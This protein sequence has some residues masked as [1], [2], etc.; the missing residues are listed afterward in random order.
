MGV[1]SVLF[2]VLSLSLVSLLVI[3][4]SGLVYGQTVVTV[5]VVENKLVTLIGEGYDEDADDLTFLWEQLDGEPVELSSYIIPTP[6][7]MAPE[8]VNGLIKVLT[9]QLTVTDPTGAESS[10]VVEIIVNPVNHVPIVSAGRDKLIFPTLNAITLVGSAVDADDDPLTFS[11]E[12]TSGPEIELVNTNLR[13]LTIISTAIDFSNFTPMTFKLTAN[14]E[15]GGAASD[16]ATLYPYHDILT[17]RLITIDAGPLQTVKEGQTVTMDVTGETLNG[18]PISYSWAQLIGPPVSLSNYVGDEVQFI[19]PDLEG[20]NSELLSFQ[21]TGYSQGNGWASDIAMVRV[22]PFNGPPTADAGPDQN[23]SQNVFVNLEGSGT[24]P[25][26]TKLRFQWSQKSGSEVTLYQRSFEDVYFV[27]PFIDGDSA[28]L[29]FGL[30]VTDSDGNFDTDDVTITVSKQNH[31]PKANAGPDRRIISDSQVT[32]TGFG[33]DPDGDEITYSWEQISGD[34]VPFDGSEAKISFTAPTVTSGDTKRVILQLKVTDTL[35]QSDTD[36]LTLIVVPENN[37]PIVDA[38]PDQEVDENTIGN[39]FCSAF[40]VEN[41][42]LTYT[43][44]AATS[45]F[46]IHNPSN[47]SATYEAPSV[48]NSEQFELTCSVSDGTFTVSDSLIVM[49]QN[50]LSLDIVANAGPDQIVNEK[51]KIT[52]DGSQSFDP[53]NQSLSYM[54]AQTSGEAVT[55]DSE[56]SVETSF[57]SPTVANNEIKVLVFELKV[58]DDNGREAFDTVIIT[59]DPV[60]SPPTAEASAIQE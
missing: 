43:W 54:W 6:K 31:P 44:T 39:L 41:D 5:D 59:V 35:K 50:T 4:S 53:E 37:K 29:V 49:V 51:V 11:W 10:D 28:D 52:L 42:P 48:L 36:R 12:Q 1:Q 16:S 22:L 45:D 26:D 34:K 3:G 21:V 7:F 18:K 25:E 15:F 20:E 56:N 24:D 46:I 27:S 32:V 19:A 30:R 17:N 55:I 8:V 38:G 58:Y 23:V 57:K 60:N 13:Y 47:P 9:F 2:M 14:D 33:V 40:D